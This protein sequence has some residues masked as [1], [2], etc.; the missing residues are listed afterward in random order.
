MALA[1]AVVAE[2]RQAGGDESAAR[3]DLQHRIAGLHVQRLE[4]ASLLDRFH[5][6]LPFTDRHCHVGECQALV[7]VFDKLLTRYRLIGAQ[8]ALVDNLPGSYLLRDHV[9][10][11]GFE[12]VGEHPRLRG[13]WRLAWCQAR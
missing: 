13:L 1:A 12:V 8:H 4:H 11:G 5:H 3:A 9:E 10:P 6:C 2:L 7:L